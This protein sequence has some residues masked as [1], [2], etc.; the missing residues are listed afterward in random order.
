MSEIDNYDQ[1]AD[2]VVMMTIHSAK[3]LEFPVVF[4]PG[5]EE[6]IFPGT[7]SMYD[8]AELE[9]ERRLAYV[10]ITRAKKRLYL[11]NATQRMLYGQTNRNPPS[12]FIQELPEENVEARTADTPGLGFG[13]AF[14]APGEKRDSRSGFSSSSAFVGESK[15]TSSYNHSFGQVK[16]DETAGMSFFAGDAVAHKTFGTGVVL[17]AQAMGNDLLLEVAFEK[18]GTKKLMAKFAK[19]TKV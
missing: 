7:Q 11:V 8:T 6:G 10:G 2:S 4:I 13:G 14:G 19:L 16:G 17:S 15:K 1:G 3:G 12:R 9:E 18:A 5:M